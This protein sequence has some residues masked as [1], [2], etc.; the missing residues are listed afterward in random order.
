MVLVVL[1]VFG[2]IFV[3]VGWFVI[4]FGCIFFVWCMCWWC[5]GGFGWLCIC[6]FGILL[7]VFGVF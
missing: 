5:I 4:V 2:C 1:I 3:F 7:F 6:V